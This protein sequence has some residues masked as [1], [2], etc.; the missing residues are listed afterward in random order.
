VNSYSTT[1]TSLSTSVVTGITQTTTTLTGIFPIATTTK[2][3]TVSSTT[4][5]FATITQAIAVTS[6]STAQ[7]VSVLASVSSAQTVIVTSDPTWLY[8]GLGIVGVLVFAFALI[9]YVLKHPQ[10][11]VA[12]QPQPQYS[13]QT[14]YM[15]MGGYWYQWNPNSG[16][17]HRVGY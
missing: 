4:S 16:Q 6:T 8:I 10:Q 15:Q 12:T 1:V 2:T 13:Q 3:E 7:V 14:G 17:W 5:A 9:V 11:P